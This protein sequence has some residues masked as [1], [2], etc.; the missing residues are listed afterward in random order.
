MAGKKMLVIVLALALGLI[1]GCAKR[2]PGKEKAALNITEAYHSVLNMPVYIAIEAG[3]FQKEGL[4]VHLTTAWSQEK[5]FQQL[6]SGS[7][8]LVLGS[9]ESL[10]YHL[11]QGNK[12]PLTYLAQTACQSG[13]YLVARPGEKPFSWQDLKG[14]TVI[15][16]QGGELQQVIFE[17]LLKKN[18]L[19]PH[20]DVHLIQNLPGELSL[21]AFQAGT[22]HFLIA[23]EPAA[24]R[25]EKEYSC[26]A[27]ATLDVLPGPL[28]TGTVMTTLDYFEKN[29]ETCA[30]FVRAIDLALKWLNEHTP[31]DI[32]A[33]S[34]K[35]FS[36][37]DEKV[38]LRA[39][40]RYKTLG[41]WPLS[42]AIHREGLDNLQDIMLE[43]KE[44]N[45]K[46]PVDSLLIYLGGAW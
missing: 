37:E 39:V 45:E 13:Y 15:G 12:V 23:A 27:V 36:Q 5:A 14:K 3:F 11:Q 20:L 41:L 19:R 8:P 28:V 42:T 9:P 1:N 2:E 18:D 25:A 4:A 44:L 43:R 31:E 22:G 6:V 32:V 30:R 16:S 34:Q 35:A 10:F 29:R 21:G 40:S 17:Y 7:S 46:I 24:A 33:A 38:L 26:R